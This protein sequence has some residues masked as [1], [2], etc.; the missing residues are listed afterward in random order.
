[1]SQICL[2][3][4]QLERWHVTRNTER[5]TAEYLID[6]LMTAYR[7]LMRGTTATSDGQ[8]TIP[9]HVLCSRS[10]Q[11][12]EAQTSLASMLL[13][14]QLLFMLSLVLHPYQAA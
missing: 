8:S 1:M 9:Q 2:H 4:G 3:V 13:H 10:Q 5:C 7:C 14:M 6:I 12:Q 11:P